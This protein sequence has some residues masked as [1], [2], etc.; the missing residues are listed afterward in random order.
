V[1]RRSVEELNVPH[2]PFHE[3]TGQETLP[4]EQIGRRVADPIEA[5]RQSAL[6][7]D[8]EGFRR[9][10]LHSESQFKRRDAGVERTVDLAVALVELVEP[11]DRVQLGALC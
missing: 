1:V 5:R 7:C 4:T 3:P 6:A 8:V 9:V 2:A 10:T 11:P